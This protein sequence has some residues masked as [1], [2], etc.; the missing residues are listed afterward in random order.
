MDTPLIPNQEQLFETLKSAQD[1]VLTAVRDWTA[2]VEGHLPEIPFA[3][4]LPKASETVD[5]AIDFAAKVLDRQREFVTSILDTVGAMFQPADG[6]VDADPVEA[7]PV[8]V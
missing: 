6:P 8:D 4:Q 5:Q 2:S 7:E 1:K 3:D